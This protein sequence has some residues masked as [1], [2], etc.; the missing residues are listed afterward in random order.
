MADNDWVKVTVAIALFAV[1]LVISYFTV[2]ILG[3]VIQIIAF[4]VLT[5][6]LF[7]VGI[8]IAGSLSPSTVIL[9]MII[10]AITSA[11]I[12]WMFSNLISVVTILVLTWI[13]FKFMLRQYAPDMVREIDEYFGGE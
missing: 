7:G 13:I 9:V 1:S 10:A 8:R 11:I 5:Y 3:A 12:V 2:S 6:Y 4:L